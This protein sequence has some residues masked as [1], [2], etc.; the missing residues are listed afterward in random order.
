M[1][2]PNYHYNLPQL[3][4]IA[5]NLSYAIFGDPEQEQRLAMNQ[6]L[7]AMREQD[8]STQA[9]AGRRAEQ[10]FGWKAADR[11][12][13]ERADQIEANAISALLAPESVEGPMPTAQ[14]RVAGAVAQGGDIKDILTGAAAGSPGARDMLMMAS[15]RLTPD[16]TMA[17]ERQKAALRPDPG[18]QFETQYRLAQEFY[19]KNGHWPRGFAPPE[20]TQPEPRDPKDVM[21]AIEK[22]EQ[23]ATYLAGGD[24]PV[25]KKAIFA[26]LLAQAGFSEQEVGQIL[27]NMGGEDPA[28]APG[29]DS[30]WPIDAFTGA[31][32]SRNP[33]PMADIG[34]GANR[35][36]L[37]PGQAGG[38]PPPPPGLGAAIDPGSVT[39]ADMAKAMQVLANPGLYDPAVVEAAQQVMTL[40]GG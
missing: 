2:R 6:Q 20:A 3:G 15:G 13:A 7:T 23:T 34:P 32:A 38:N 9:A 30:L 28:Q 16:E 10:E 4:R 11:A 31:G 17:L 8:M 36:G 24:D 33:S 26:A 40:I 22:A 37:T 18:A 5:E 39:E 27:S 14:E 25:A 29:G 35:S 21:E 1:F 19:N 12:K